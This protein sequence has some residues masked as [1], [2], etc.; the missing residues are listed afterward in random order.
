[1]CVLPLIVLS[2][3]AGISPGRA[4]PAEDAVFAM[5]VNPFMFEAI[6]TDR[7]D[8]GKAEGASDRCI[9][10]EFESRDPACAA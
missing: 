3:S 1:M 9:R 7:A 5:N 6:A 2:V 8:A 4:E 10:R